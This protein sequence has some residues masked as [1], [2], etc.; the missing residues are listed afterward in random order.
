VKENL[1][2]KDVN[3]NLVEKMQVNEKLIQDLKDQ[4]KQQTVKIDD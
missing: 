3:K 2:L 4:V 1:N